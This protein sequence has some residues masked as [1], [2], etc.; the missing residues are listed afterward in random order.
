MATFKDFGPYLTYAESVKSQT[1]TLKGIENIPNQDQYDNMI[2]VYHD[3]YEPCCR[4]FGIK[5]P[6][7]SFFRSVKLNKAIGGAATSAHM[8]GCAIDMD[9]DTV[10]GVSNRQ[11]FDWIRANLKFDQLILESPDQHGNPQWVHVANNREGK[12]NR[13]Q[14]LK[15]TRIN[16]KPVYETI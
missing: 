12:P 8:A 1:A 7:P 16:G 6:V 2:E 9:A 3:F 10:P 13:Q 14:V 11:L 15:M 5:F 4:H